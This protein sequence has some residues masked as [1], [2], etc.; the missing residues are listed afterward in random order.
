MIIITLYNEDGTSIEDF[1]ENPL[2]EKW[3]K[4]FPKKGVCNVLK[5]N[6]IANY[7]CIN[8]S[9]CPNGDLFEVPKEDLEEYKKYL[10]KVLEYN[11][12]HNPSLTQSISYKLKKG[13]K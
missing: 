7:S 6:N 3:L 8:C 10:E 2:K 9:K 12:I 1:P 5:E 13:N 11:T 4:Q